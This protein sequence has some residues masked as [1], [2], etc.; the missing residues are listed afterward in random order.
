MS[1]ERFVEL[2]EKFLD[3]ELSPSEETELNKILNANPS[4][5][6]ELE[7]QIKVKWLEKLRINS[8]TD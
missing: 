2:V 4:F 1:D 3:N 8:Q 7:E 5:K 6:S